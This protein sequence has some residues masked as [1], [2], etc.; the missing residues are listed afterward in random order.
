[1]LPSRQDVKELRAQI[2][3]LGKQTRK[4]AKLGK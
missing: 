3:D 4:L 2:E 1:M